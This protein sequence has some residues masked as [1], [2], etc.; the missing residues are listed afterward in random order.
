[1][2]TLSVQIHKAAHKVYRRN[3]PT[4]DYSMRAANLLKMTAAHESAQFRH[5]RQIGFSPHSTRGAF[6]LF[7]LEWISISSSLDY[8]DRRPLLRK[9]ALDYLSE[10]GFDETILNSRAKPA[11]LNV[12]QQPAGDPL[13]AMFARV[14]YLQRPGKIPATPEGMADYAK[15]HYNTSAGKATAEDYLKAYRAIIRSERA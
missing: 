10:Y 12:L 7:Q 2:T 11:I 14:H 13:G 8:L 6:S 5:R 3:R 1:M 4:A 9:H 15:Q